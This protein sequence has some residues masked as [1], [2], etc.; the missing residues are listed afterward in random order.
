MPVILN[1]QTVLKTN[2]S[3]SSF[4]F[5]FF[6][7]FFLLSFFTFK[8]SALL[9]QVGSV[10]HKYLSFFFFIFFL[11]SFFSLYFPFLYLY[12][13]PLVHLRFMKQIFSVS[14]F[15]F[16]N[17]YNFQYFGRI[18]GKAVL[19]C[20]YLFEDSFLLR[21][22]GISPESARSAFLLTTGQRFCSKLFTGNYF[23]GA[24]CKPTSLSVDFC[25][26]TEDSFPNFL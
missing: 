1:Q 19:S 26:Q 9:S 11:L 20:T 4:F 13:S 18:E 15:P 5:S 16:L 10:K 22:S 17:M 12:L 3:L 23:P 8:L 14:F 2:V 21:A 6:L 25:S 24:D 7:S